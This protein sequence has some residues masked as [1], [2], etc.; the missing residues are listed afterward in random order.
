MNWHVF[1]VRLSSF[2]TSFCSHLPLYELHSNWLSL[3]SSCTFPRF[4]L[5]HEY[6]LYQFF[7]VLLCSP[8]FF[9]H[10]TLLFLYPFSS[11]Q[12]CTIDCLIN[13]AEAVLFSQFSIPFIHSKSTKTPFILTCISLAF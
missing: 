2:S 10:S 6:F 5:A 13:S 11:L 4:L 3:P 8:A 1:F 12:D 7:L 9:T